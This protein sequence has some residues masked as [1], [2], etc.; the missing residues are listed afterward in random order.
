MLFIL[1]FL[2]VIFIFGIAVGGGLV[3]MDSIEEATTIISE[4][5]DILTENTARFKSWDEILGGK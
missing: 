3:S 1:I 5:D 2:V 4:S